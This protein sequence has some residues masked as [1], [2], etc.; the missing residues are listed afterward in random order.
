MEV[1]GGDR[2]VKGSGE[3][4]RDR[5]IVPGEG[6]IATPRTLSCGCLVTEYERVGRFASGRSGEDGCLVACSTAGVTGAGLHLM[7]SKEPERLVF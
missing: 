5:D 7:T 3:K 6:I 4:L 2:H 1:R